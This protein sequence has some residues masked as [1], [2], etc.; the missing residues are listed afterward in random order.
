MAIPNQFR[1]NKKLNNFE[2]KKGKEHPKDQLK[3]V[4]R[5]NQASLRQKLGTLT[6]FMLTFFISICQ[7]DQHRAR[8]GY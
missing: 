1:N 2:I 4:D 6:W 3:N 5:R 7:L 8:F